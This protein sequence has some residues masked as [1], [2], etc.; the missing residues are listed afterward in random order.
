[1]EVEFED[2]MFIMILIECVYMEE[3]VGKFMYMGGLMGW[4]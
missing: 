3:D 4:I 1:M 2:G